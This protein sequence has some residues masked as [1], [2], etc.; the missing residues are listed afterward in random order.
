MGPKAARL[1][2]TAQA[3]L[4]YLPHDMT[5]RRIDASAVAQEF[6]DQLRQQLA[7]L[8]GPLT[9]AGFLATDAAPSRTYADYTRIGCED[10]G[11]RFD[12]R[13]VDK[14]GVEDAIQRANSEPYV[15]GIIV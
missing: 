10:L 4:G 7:R 3:K 1:G 13:E 11:I 9:L 5:A 2:L 12:L 6:R 15:H 14:L 8:R